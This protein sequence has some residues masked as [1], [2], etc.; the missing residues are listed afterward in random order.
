MRSGS[1]CVA[2]A[3]EDDKHKVPD[4]KDTNFWVPLTMI[5]RPWITYSFLAQLIVYD[6]ELH[7]YF[8]IQQWALVMDVVLGYKL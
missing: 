3:W 7:P 1:V 4:L 5:V 8:W 6:L 2:Y